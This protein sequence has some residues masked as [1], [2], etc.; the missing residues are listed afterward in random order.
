MSFMI[1]LMLSQTARRDPRCHR[2]TL[3]HFLYRPSPRLQRYRLHL[4]EIRKHTDESNYDRD[5]TTQAM[6]V[7]NDQLQTCNAGMVAAELR[8]KIREYSYTFDSL[9]LRG[10]PVSG[11]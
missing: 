4:Q 1:D 8:A 7:I 11:S 10:A 6:D 3:D 2:L 5:S 9:R